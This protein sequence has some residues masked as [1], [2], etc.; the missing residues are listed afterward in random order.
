MAE[1]QV[2]TIKTLGDFSVSVGDKLLSEKTTRASQLW[3]LFKYLITNRTAQLS[4]EKLIDVLWPE[5]EVDDPLKALY[6]L[7]YRLRATLSAPFSEKQDFI[8]FKHDAYSWNQNAPYALDAD[9]FEQLFQAGEAEQ[10]ADKK[11]EL[12]D[13]AF[14]LYRGNYLA[15]LSFEIWSLPSANFYKRTYAGVVKRLSDLC[16]EKGDYEGVVRYNERAIELDPF[17][18]SMHHDLIDALIKLNLKS[19]AVAHYNYLSSVLYN[20]LGVTPSDRL[21]ALY[22]QIYEEMRQTPRDIGEI[23]ESLRE[24]ESLATG[25]FFCDPDVF[26]KIYQLE[27]RTLE[28]TQ[29][30]VVLGCATLR[31][32]F[33]D[34]PNG[35]MVNEGM[36]H[37]KRTVM[38]GLRR[39]DIVTQYSDSQLLMLLPSVT[40]ENCDSIAER[41]TDRF[42]EWPGSGE[43]DLAFEFLPLEH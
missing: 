17:E 43:L 36:S 16:A 32:V 35:L 38:L 14:R 3:K 15:E 27:I 22:R 28:R 24:Q 21:V 6:S 39:G 18:E 30:S 20:E 4:T 11:F 1:N 31:D 13:R 34:E 26:R 37:L 2:L 33:S 41:L 40:P 9:E 29:T 19:Q 25:V 7:V 8:L 23:A 42:V 12:Y 10:D 5:N